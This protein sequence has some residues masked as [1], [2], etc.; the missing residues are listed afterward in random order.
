MS[1]DLALVTRAIMVPLTFGRGSN[2]GRQHRVSLYGT[3]AIVTFSASLRLALNPVRT[4]T[5]GCA[6]SSG[7]VD[8]I[9]VS[10]TVS[11]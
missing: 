2:A 5:I 11:T 4:T 1:F 10:V 7:N 9:D 6:N 8:R 3:A